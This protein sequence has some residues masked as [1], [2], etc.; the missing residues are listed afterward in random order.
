M[1]T[2]FDALR[3]KERDVRRRT[4]ARI[5][6]DILQKQG[7]DAVT[8]RNVARAAGLSTGAI[9]MY[10]QNKEEIFI[11]LLIENLKALEKDFKKSMQLSEPARAFA[12]MAGDYRKYYLRFGKFIDLFS[13]IPE[14]QPPDVDASLMEELRERLFGI[15]GQ[16][17]AMLGAPGMQKALKGVPPKRAV[18]V[19]WSLITGLAHVTLPSARSQESGFDFSQVLEDCLRIMM[20]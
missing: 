8:I 19:L 12:S 15:L 14:K 3:A 20:P 7:L 16:V 6:E 10:F 17:E 9:Y 5:A 18:P 2:A 13:L 11:H 1:A 4:I